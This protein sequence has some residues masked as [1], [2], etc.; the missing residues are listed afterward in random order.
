MFPLK[1]V[2]TYKKPG[3]NTFLPTKSQCTCSCHSPEMGTTLRHFA[4]C[5]HPDNIPDLT[6]RD[7]IVLNPSHGKDKPDQPG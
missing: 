7:G 1:R 4:P 5:C 6:T 2:R 3:G